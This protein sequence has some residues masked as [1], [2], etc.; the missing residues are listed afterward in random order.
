MLFIAGVLVVIGSVM[1]GY[2]LHGGNVGV[3]YQPTEYLI[4]LGAGIG[5]FLIANPGKIVK[6][7][8]GSLKFLLK[9]KPFSKAD[10]IELLVMQYSVFKL[11]KT[12]G[13]L[14]LEQHIENPHESDL[15]GQ[16]PKFAH[17]HHALDFFCDNLRLMT[18]GMEDQYQMEDL[19]DA[20]LDQHHHETHQI[21]AAVVTLGDSFPAIGIVAA[22]LGV[23]ITM[24]SISEPPEILGGL[25]AAALVGT[26][27]GI[28]VA[29]GFVGPMGQFIGKYFEDEAKYMEALKAGIL[30][31]LK[32]NAPA[33]SVEFAR[34]VIP[35]AEK[36]SF[37]EIEEAQDAAG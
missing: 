12:K 18:M 5:S 33:V 15:F 35:S 34:A 9:G 29:Y 31:H 32:G 36:P 19:M 17:N 10:Y 1:G 13:M 2:I 28:F 24:G 21:G 8:I 30:S 23:I 11:M 20:T 14:E 7:S 3:L 16:Y 37:A 27:L 4:I 25:I 26:F 6:G 22:V